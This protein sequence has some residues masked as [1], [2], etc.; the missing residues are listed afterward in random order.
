MG[1]SFSMYAFRRQHEATPADQPAEPVRL[2]VDRRG[3]RP[4]DRLRAS[5]FLSRVGRRL[6]RQPETTIDE[7][8]AAEWRV[9]PQIPIAAIACALEAVQLAQAALA[10]QELDDADAAEDAAEDLSNPRALLNLASRF[11]R[12]QAEVQAGTRHRSALDLWRTVR[13]RQIVEDAE[14]P[15]QPVPFRLKGRESDSEAPAA[16]TGSTAPADGDTLETDDEPHLPMQVLV[17][18]D[19]PDIRRFLR[20]LLEGEGH[21]VSAAPDGLQALDHIAC[22]RPDLVLLDL[23]MPRMTGWEVRDELDR[24][25]VE[26]PVVFM[27]AG[28]RARAEAERHRVAGYLAKPFSID[29]L[30]AIIER[31]RSLP[32]RAG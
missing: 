8:V 21:A 32:T 28:D 30:L 13:S 31:I 12:T 16:D 15:Y 23:Q 29:D 17:V 18:D 26:V 5:L 20:L 10:E 3:I 19:D 9:D 24:R 27:T 22:Q 4:T 7:G 6:Q 2:N 1:T 14:V 25:R 11:L